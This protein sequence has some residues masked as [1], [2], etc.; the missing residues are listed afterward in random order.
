VLDFSALV[1][2]DVGQSG[3]AWIF[4]FLSRV[5][6]EKGGSASL[7]EMFCRADSHPPKTPPTQVKSLRHTYTLTQM[8]ERSEEREGNPDKDVG[9]DSSQRKGQSAMK[10]KEERKVREKKTKRKDSQVGK[11]KVKEL[12]EKSDGN[13]E[14]PKDQ[15]GH[16]T[17]ECSEVAKTES[18]ASAVDQELD[19]EKAEPDEAMPRPNIP[20]GG[21]SEGT[22]RLARGRACLECKTSKVSETA[23]FTGR[24]VV[25]LDHK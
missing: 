16:E 8:S 11:S 4:G 19:R 14:A 9:E 1:P 18:L 3:F 13:E 5:M 2:L 15:T 21:T 17:R 22:Q 10:V 7:Y 6:P 24:K 20:K 23:W 12:K 25:C